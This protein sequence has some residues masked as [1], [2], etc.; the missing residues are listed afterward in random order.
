MSHL[1]DKIR[2]ALAMD[3]TDLLQRMD[4]QSLQEKIVDSFRG[5]SRW[6]VV[7]TF[8]GTF[9]FTV[10]MFLCAAAFFQAESVRALVGWSVGFLFCSLTVSLFKIFYWMELHKNTVTRELKRLELQV[11]RLA[12]RL[13]EASS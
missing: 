2:Q 3:D 8:V 11:A 10:L 12:Q 4:E 6:L 13:E 7:L 1:D 5:R 9:V